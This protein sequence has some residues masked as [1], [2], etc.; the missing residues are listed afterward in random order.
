VKLEKTR[1]NARDLLRLDL[2]AGGGFIG[3]FMP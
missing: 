3:R 1:V 2:R